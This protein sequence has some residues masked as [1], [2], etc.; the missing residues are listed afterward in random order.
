MTIFPPQLYSYK[1]I[2]GTQE[3]VKC[4][5]VARFIMISKQIGQQSNSNLYKCFH[6][7]VIKFESLL[8]YFVTVVYFYSLIHQCLC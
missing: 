4:T 2:Y 1:Y 8:L 5:N 6:Y 7:Q 3:K